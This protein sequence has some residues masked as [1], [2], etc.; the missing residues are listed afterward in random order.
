MEGYQ[1]K[2]SHLESS[3]N[4][5]SSRNSEL[6]EELKI[7]KE[8]C[9]GHEDRAKMHYQRSLELEDLFQTSHSRLED[10]GKKA[11]E[12]KL[13]FEAEKYRVKELEEQNSACERKCV[14]AEAD[15]RKYYD[16]ISEL[17]SEIEVCLAKSSN[18]EVSLQMVVAREKELTESLNLVTDEKKNLEEA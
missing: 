10:A 9:A 14:D 8:Q 12:F 5:S 11:R 16:K 13:L 3:L 4:Q 15:S 6:E 18:L 7:A 2:I 17:A 1:E